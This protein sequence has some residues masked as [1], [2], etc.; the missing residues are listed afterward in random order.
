MRVHLSRRCHQS[1]NQNTVSFED[2]EGEKVFFAV[3]GVRWTDQKDPKVLAQETNYYKHP[4]NLKI[5]ILIEV[6]KVH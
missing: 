1:H 6:P 3:P 5:E 2:V 4:Q